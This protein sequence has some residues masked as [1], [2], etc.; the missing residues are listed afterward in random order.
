MTWKLRHGR[1]LETQTW[2]DMSET[3]PTPSPRS[4]H[5]M[6]SVNSCL[7]VF[8]GCGAKGRLADLHCFDCNTQTWQELPMCDAISGRGGAGFI[9]SSDGRSLFVVGGFSGK[10]MND[11]FKYDIESKTW[12]TIYDA[13]DSPVQ[14]FSVSCSA[15]IGSQMIFFGGEI[16]PSE[17]GHEGAGGFSNAL[18]CFD[19]ASGIITSMKLAP[20]SP[21][22]TPRGWSDADAFEQ[23][24]LV[25]F[26][27]LTGDDKNPV[28]LNDLWI[29]E[30][31]V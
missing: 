27:G 29:L 22:P 13:K 7:Y 8:G 4:F 9:G 20:D 23:E 6:V 1:I 12:A 31:V 17:K 5:K 19:S 26:G 25:V 28:R 10:E 2:E 16:D 30:Q 24:S 3:N 11:V 21:V 18:Q 15:L 14:P